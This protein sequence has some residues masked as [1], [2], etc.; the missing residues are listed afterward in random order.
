MKKLFLIKV[1]LVSIF[2]N[3]RRKLLEEALRILQ[4]SLWQSLKPV[5]KFSDFVKLL[6]LL[7]NIK[8]KRVLFCDLKQFGSLIRFVGANIS[9][10]SETND[11][12]KNLNKVLTLSWWR[13]L[14]YRN[15][16]IDLRS[17]SMDW[18]LYDN[19]LHHERVNSSML[20]SPARM[21]LSYLANI[22]LKLTEI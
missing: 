11:F 7:V 14:S 20:K 16:S 8:S 4:K 13:P 21:T 22:L 9:F 19:G 18:F 5:S 15:H 2:Y 10:I 6:G 17:K 3:F 12:L 1:F